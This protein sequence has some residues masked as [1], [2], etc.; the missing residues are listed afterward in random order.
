MT[1]FLLVGLS[2]LFFSACIASD[3]DN[4]PANTMTTS[5]LELQT[6]NALKK[7]LEIEKQNI[8]KLKVYLGN[9]HKHEFASLFGDLIYRPVW[10][11]FDGDNAELNEFRKS[12]GRILAI[13]EIYKYKLC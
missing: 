1:K 12:K 9:E 11:F 6:C 5:R 2:L 10:L 4:I 13:E 3:P 7:Q 8:L